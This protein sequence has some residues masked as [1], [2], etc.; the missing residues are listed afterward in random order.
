[1]AW[2]IYNKPDDILAYDNVNN[3]VCYYPKVNTKVKG[4]EGRVILQYKGATVVDAVWNTEVTV[5]AGSADLKELV[6]TIH[7]YL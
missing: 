3:D 1:M 4:F 7:G 6:E 5:P 2:E